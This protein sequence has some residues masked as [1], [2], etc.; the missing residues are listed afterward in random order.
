MKGKKEEAAKALGRLT[1]LP[2]DD[3]EVQL[4]LNDI[5]TALKEEQALGESTYLD[6]FK[7]SHNKIMFRTLTGIFIQGWQQLTGI[8]FIFYCTSLLFL[9]SNFH[10]KLTLPSHRRYLVLPELRY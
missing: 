7:S 1:S 8:N 9:F 5:E 4:E 6:C 2:A 10:T 3:P